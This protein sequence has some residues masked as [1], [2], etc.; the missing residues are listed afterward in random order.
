MSADARAGAAVRAGAAAILARVLRGRTTPEAA[1]AAETRFGERDAALLKALVLGALRW[2]H[3]L[4]WQLGQLLDRPLERDQEALAALLRSGLHQ[5][6]ASRIPEHAAVS[7]T[8]DAA[9]LLGLGRAK[10]LVNAVLRR[11]LRERAALDAR[12][13]DVPA[14]LHSHPDWLIAALARDWPDEWRAVL[15]ANNAAPPLWLRVNARKLDRDRYVAEH[16]AGL[17]LEPSRE[18]PQAVRLLEPLPAERIPGFA[19]GLVSVQDA[20]AQLAAPLLDARPGQR[21]LDACAAPGGKACH[22]LET[23][24]DLGELWALDVDAARL[25]RVRDNLGRLGLT[26]RLVRGDATEPAEWWDGRPFERILLDAPCS[27]TGVIRRHPDIKVLRTPRDVERATALQDRLLDA[28]WPL[29]APGGRLLY[30][31]CSALACENDARVA[32]FLA[33]TPDAVLGASRNVR[34]GQ[35]NMDGFYYA[36]LDKQD[37]APRALDRKLP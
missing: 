24:P 14:A 25:E 28:L 37:V 8:V 7:A 10:G 3:R 11:F 36:C 31:T 19:A 32:A 18:A 33:R 17:E 20:A 30:A 23:C 5:L 13:R 29:L 2:H 12:M 35:A 21:V 9:G 1:F 15:D 6:Q 27:G 16:A 26:A 34:P 22:V 4:D